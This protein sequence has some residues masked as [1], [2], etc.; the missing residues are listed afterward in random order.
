MLLLQCRTDYV[1]CNVGGNVGCKEHLHSMH[2]LLAE[3]SS[4]WN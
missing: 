2:M 3:S 1:G 4:I